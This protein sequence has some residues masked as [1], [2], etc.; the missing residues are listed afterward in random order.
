MGEKTNEAAKQFETGKLMQAALVLIDREKNEYFSIPKPKKSNGAHVEESLFGKLKL[1]YKNN[2]KSV[3]NNARLI[4]AVTFSPCKNC[5][6][7][8][9]PQFMESLKAVHRGIQIKFRFQHYWTEAS[10]K[11][12]GGGPQITDQAFWSSEDEAEKAYDQLSRE[13]G[14]QVWESAFKPDTDQEMEE[15][16]AYRGAIVRTMIK[17]PNLVIRKIDGAPS[18]LSKTHYII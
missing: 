12:A 17:R 8:V 14:C 18:R 10:W 11:Q 9:I 7:N 1:H 13:Y 5:T 6:K 16:S 3:P 15:W 2:L 4:V